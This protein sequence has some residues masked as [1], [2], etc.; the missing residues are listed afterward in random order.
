M[1][2]FAIVLAACG[3][4]TTAPVEKPVVVEAPKRVVAPPVKKDSLRP[5][6]EA[7][8]GGAITDLAITPDGTAAVT[9]DEL[10]ELRLWPTLDG[11]REPCVVDLPVPTEFAITSRADGFAI[12]VVDAADTLTIATIDREGRTLHRTAVQTDS[13]V[14]GVAATATG[15]VAWME[16]Q[17]ITVFASDGKPAGRLGAEPG[18]RLE[19][20]TVGGSHGLAKLIVDKK[21]IVRPFELGTLA[22][23]A[24]L[25]LGG[26][27]TG[28]IAISPSG[29]RIAAV[30]ETKP[31]TQQ[32]RILEGKKLVSETAQVQWVGFIDD[33]TAATLPTNTI[34]FVTDVPEK[35]KPKLAIT[36]TKL[37]VGA[38]VAI[39]AAGSELSIARP[40][41][42]GY[43]GYD[44]QSPQVATA[45]PDHHLVIGVGHQFA[46]VDDHLIAIPGAAVPRFTDGVT[47]AELQWL[48]GNDYYAETVAPNGMTGF[49]VANDK[50][51]PDAITQTYAGRSVAALRYEPT[52]QLLASYGS[53]L[54]R[55]DPTKHATVKIDAPKFEQIVPL[56]PAR[57]NGAELVVVETNKKSQSHV[58]W[59]D[60]A[61]KKQIG[62][63]A[64]IESFLTADAAGHVYAWTLD[65]P[66]KTLALSILGPDGRVA[67]LPH[68]GITTMWPDLKGERA[69][70]VS[71]SNI[72]LY[73]IDGTPLWKL[74]LVG[75][76]EAVWTGDD[77]VSIV[78]VSGIVRIDATTGAPLAARCG[79]KFGLS[80]L[81]HPQSARI[82]PVCTQLR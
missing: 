49:V 2:R 30:V 26:N 35:A 21:E 14:N 23:G 45:G 44:L 48:T 78:T 72:T 9:V 56:D 46:Q 7:P 82:N 60:L 76:S 69:L 53:V 58:M 27:A 75:A 65:T 77:A 81:P 22:W 74:P 73:K 4:G 62:K 39:A 34:V 61:G 6:I 15:F 41:G 57:A 16:D 10:D 67:T 54:E 51:P 17:S 11:T 64:A 36:A 40:D 42:G 13:A 20:V 12:A 32:L 70:E 38:G 59:T 31:G 33:H 71:A 25:D 24:P 80:Q 19:T 68:D 8:H 1:K 5:R 3:G 63:R 52:T 37:V 29:A 43:L 79:W 50:P 47:V 55:W 66:D 28:A 18:Q